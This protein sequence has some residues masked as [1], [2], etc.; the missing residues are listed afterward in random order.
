MTAEATP[1]RAWTRGED[2]PAVQKL[3]LTAAM[4]ALGVV[5]SYF[6]VPVGPAR[7]FPFQHL[8]NVI[9]GIMLGPSHAVLAA[10]A[11]A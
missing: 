3:A 1:V 5:L 9:A 11:S 8:L 4:V 7:V 2:L 6:S 10:L